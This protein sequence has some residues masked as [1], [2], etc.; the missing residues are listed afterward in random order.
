MLPQNAV[1]VS[2]VIVSWNVKELLLANLAR[3]FSMPTDV[4]FEVFV[5][6]N[7]SVD[8]SAKMVRKDFPNVRLIQNDYNAGFAAACNQALRVAKG[9]VLLL[10]N[11]DM[12]MG[13]GALSYAYKTLRERSD[14]GVLGIRL[15]HEDGTVV[16]SVRRDPTLLDQLA[17]LF[18]IPHIFPRVV[19]RYLAKDFDYTRSQEVEQVRGSFFA[20]RRDVMVRVG[21]LDERFFVWFE[22]VDFCKRV[23]EQGLKIWYSAEVSCHD[24]VGQ[25]FKQQPVWLKQFRFFRS[26]TQYMLKWWGHHPKKK[27]EHSEQTLVLQLLTFNRVETLQPLFDSLAL[28]TDQDFELLV[29]DNSTDASAR[30]KIRSVLEAQRSRFRIRIFYEDGNLGFAGGHQKLYTLHHAAYVQLLNDDAVLEP[31]YIEKL[32]TFLTT[33]SY[34]GAV[35][36]AVLRCEIEQGAVTKTDI[37]DSLGLARTWYE[38]VYDIDAGKR[39]PASSPQPPSSVFGISGCLPMYRRLAV[40]SQLFDPRYFM[41]KEDVD[42]AYRLQY[43]G[44][45]AYVLP[46]AIGYHARSFRPSWTKRPYRMQLLS[47]KNH[48]RNLRHLTARDWIIRGWLILPYETLKAGYL[49]LRLLHSRL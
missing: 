7:G 39:I 34:A 43:A 22:E 20:F 14:I 35:S 9:E 40:G 42:L 15:T 12:L 18:K 44:W 13:D 27:I 29:L 49:F 21:F 33:H 1:N 45:E 8:G 6:D 46:N 16:P 28:Q 32:R 30:E 41:Y 11:P 24:L 48:L 23:R 4:S 36:G 19:D 38:K 10:F 2:I 26:L 25:A 47:Y 5:V 3:L 17:I 31:T 37:V